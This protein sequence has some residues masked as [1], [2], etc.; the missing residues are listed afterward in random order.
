MILEVTPRGY[1]TLMGFS[2]QQIADGL[3]EAGADA[4]GSNCGNGIE[5]VDEV[6]RAFRKCSG[7][8]IAIQ[9]NAGLPLM[10]GGTPVYPETPEFTAARAADL[11]GLGVSIIGGCCGT[12]PAHTKAL[13]AMFDAAGAQRM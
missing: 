11:L 6:A 7:M 9:A 3:R 2:V 8:P 4:I 13:R 1:H 12:T 5:A 10:R